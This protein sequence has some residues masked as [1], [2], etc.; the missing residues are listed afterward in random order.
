MLTS[1]INSGLEMERVYDLMIYNSS[2]III[3]NIMS[4]LK[5]NYGRGL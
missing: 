2:E 4:I 5:F 3:D 1:K